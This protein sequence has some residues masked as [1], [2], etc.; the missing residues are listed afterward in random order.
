L[1]ARSPPAVDKFQRIIPVA[2]N[3]ELA[4]VCSCP[5]GVQSAPSSARAF[6]L[7]L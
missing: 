4:P 6:S 1:A 5:G 2:C 7:A 3:E